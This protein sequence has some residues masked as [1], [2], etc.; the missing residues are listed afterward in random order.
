MPNPCLAQ[1]SLSTVYLMM[2]D[3]ARWYRINKL[4]SYL[5]LG[6]YV[7]VWKDKDAIIH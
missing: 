5:I 6:S 3:F 2:I 4:K 7:H 1:Y